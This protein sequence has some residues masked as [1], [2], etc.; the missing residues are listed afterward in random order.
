V[1]R[2]E[3]LLAIALFLGARRRVLARDVAAKF[4]VSLRTVYRDMRALAAAGFPV[5]GNAGDGYRLTQD[6]YLR[7]LALTGEEAEALALAA[8]GYGATVTASLKDPLARATAKLEAVLDRPTRG[9]VRELERRIVV[10]ELARATGPDAQVLAALRER[11]A[12][13][14]VYAPPDGERTSREIEPL[15]MVCR[16]D[17]WWLVAYCKLRG[18]ARAFRLD[19]IE[20]WQPRAPFAPRP[21][22]SFEDVIARD[23][24]LAERLF[25][26]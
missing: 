3:R 26:Y 9:R 15:G 16:G 24:H 25:G 4:G 22:F 6:S 21:G 23:R 2:L 18:D 12:V 11:H 20:R 17:A 19:A 7:P 8:H 10:P 13:R 14:I 5:E 1:N